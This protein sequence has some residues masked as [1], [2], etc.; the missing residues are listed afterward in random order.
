MPA[1]RLRTWRC[2]GAAARLKKDVNADSAFLVFVAEYC[3]HGA[4]AYGEHGLDPRG[5]HLRMGCCCV[6]GSGGA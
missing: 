4:M 3:Q 2:I 6:G 5:R 1:G